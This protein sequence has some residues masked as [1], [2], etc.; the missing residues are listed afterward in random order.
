[1]VAASQV[2]DPA[3][4]GAFLAEKMQGSPGLAKVSPEFLRDSWLI[5]ANAAGE[6]V[7]PYYTRENNL[8]AYKRRTAA[9]KPLSAPGSSLSGV[10]YGEW[11]DDD[12]S[13]P[14]LLCEGES[15]SWAAS[16]ALPEYCVLGLPAG[17]GGH[18]SAAS[19]LARRTVVLAFDAD[20]AGKAA[21][22]KWTKALLAEGCTVEMVRLPEGKDLASVHDIPRLVESTRHLKPAPD[23]IR[24]EGDTYVRPGK[25]V[26]TMLTNWRFVADTELA[27]PSGLAYEGTLLPGGRRTTISGGDLSSKARIVSWCS[28]RGL[29]WLGS[30]ADAQQLSA[31]L[32]HQG[33]FLAAGSLVNYAGLYGESFVWP[34]HRIG[35][36][37]VVYSPPSFDVGLDQR[38]G[39]ERGRYT[40]AQV[41]ELRRLHTEAV[42]DPFLAWL[43]VAPLRSTLESFPILAI[44]GSSGSGKTTL[45]DT[46][47]SAFTGTS[48]STNLTSTTKHAVAALMASTN[49]FPVWFDEYRPGA[50]KDTLLAFEQLLRDAYTGQVSSKGGLGEHWSEVT[51][52]DTHAPIIVSGED[53]FTETSHTERMVNLALPSAGKEPEVLQDVSQWGSTGFPHAYLTFLSRLLLEESL[54]V[55]PAGPEPLPAR[56]RMNLGTLRLGW[57]LLTKFC[58]LHNLD[59]PAPDFSLVENM[60]METAG[61]NPIKDALK[62]ALEESDC[63]LFARLDPEQDAV[64]IRVENFVSYIT[65]F[66]TFVLPGKSEAV[67]RYLVDN[68][69]GVPATAEFGGKKVSCLRLQ[70]SLIDS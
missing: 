23:K 14:V 54:S 56:Q 42:M 52:M 20:D 32:Q 9:T 12:V 28:R 6:I 19:T 29:A 68:Y 59:L 41:T 58:A 21:T 35:S 47:V 8:V 64:F 67:R 4:V 27:G 51:A 37:P 1:V 43:A 2:A 24:E 17:A 40:A 50:R 57:S 70:A 39:I 15:D 7:I 69:A 49:A 63:Y 26:N 45:I 10:L 34:E 38:I 55:E 3:P 53:T 16:A 36:D 5:G 62:W 31:L 22:E 44:T 18:A 66:A 60:G 11:R 25:D 33:P 65:R 13:L 46:V 30:D 48:I 61:H